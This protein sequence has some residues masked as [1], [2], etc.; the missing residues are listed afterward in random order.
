MKLDLLRATDAQ[1]QQRPL[2]LEAAE[3][4]LDAPRL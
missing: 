4:A 3:L 2:M 1:R